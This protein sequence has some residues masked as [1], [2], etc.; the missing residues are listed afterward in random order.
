MIH[1][2]AIYQLSVSFLLPSAQLLSMLC[3]GSLNTLYEA[4]QQSYDTPFDFVCSPIQFSFQEDCTQ[5]K[6]SWSGTMPIY[7][8]LLGPK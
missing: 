3:Q 5:L 4:I 6:G 7:Y 2:S 8:I 1:E